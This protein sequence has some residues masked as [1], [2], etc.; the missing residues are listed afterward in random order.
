MSEKTS[1][2]DIPGY[3][4]RYISKTAGKDLVQTLQTS[5]IRNSKWMESLPSDLLSY[6][7][8][9]GK[10]TLSQVLGH[11]LDCERIFAYRALCFARGEG[12]VLSGF[13]QDDYVAMSNVKSWSLKQMLEEYQAVRMSTISL[14]KNLDSE[15]LGRSGKFSGNVLSVEQIGRIILGHEIHH[16]EVIDERYLK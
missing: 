4:M 8:A 6:A 5:F 3:F 13:E 1:A 2:T 16:L 14:F 7:Y 11:V 15:S 12:Q 9:P 10:W